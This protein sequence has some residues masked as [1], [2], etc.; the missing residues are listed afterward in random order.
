MGIHWSS[1]A[2]GAPAYAAL[3]LSLAGC[4]TVDLGDT[5]TDINLC[6]PPGGIE[7]FQN[8]IWPNY[9][10]P[11][12]TAKGCTKNGGCHNE[13][14]GNALNFKTNPVDFPF[15]F[16]Q[17]QVFLNCGTPEMSPLLS[18]P[19]G[20]IDTHGGGDIYATTSDPGVQVFLGWF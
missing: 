15:N 14:G 5:P 2:R 10:R 12:D 9:I 4:P 13:A 7:Y 17:A 16:R 1:R 20:G 6:N 3:A 18:K 8:E 11:A 19:L